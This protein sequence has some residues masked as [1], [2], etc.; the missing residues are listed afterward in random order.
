MKEEPISR[1]AL[2]E[3]MIT[4][5]KKAF[6]DAKISEKGLLLLEI[7]IDKGYTVLQ[8]FESLW[9]EINSGMEVDKSIKNRIDVLLTTCNMEKF[10][11]DEKQMLKRALL[12]IKDENFLTNAKNAQV[13]KKPF[14][15]DLYT[16]LSFDFDNFMMFAVEDNMKKA[17]VDVDAL[18]K[19]GEKHVE[20]LKVDLWDHTFDAQGCKIT[21]YSN[22]GA[23]VM[24]NLLASPNRIKEITKGK[25][26]VGSL[27]F[28]DTLF[29]TPAISEGETLQ[30]FMAQWMTSQGMI[31]DHFKP[32]PI[33]E[34]PFIINEDGTVSKMGLPA[35]AKGSGGVM[36]AVS[37][38]K[39]TGKKKVEGMMKIE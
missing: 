33:S 27:P 4:E 5:L 8:N 12:Q 23:P 19:A 38:D 24:H 26:C 34:K 39:E 32:Y 30:A 9:D 22:K 37:V 15:N 14:V 29:V 21:V 36:M 17:K 31:R 2:H 35:A 25:R 28:R 16:V 18:W 20:E 10:L 11:A 6:P 7:K 1:E 3:R 13:L